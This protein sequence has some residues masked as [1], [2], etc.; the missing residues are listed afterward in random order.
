[1]RSQVIIVD[2]NKEICRIAKYKQY[3]N[4]NLLRVMVEEDN[5]KVD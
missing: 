1:M 2:I 5:K 4:N 3:D